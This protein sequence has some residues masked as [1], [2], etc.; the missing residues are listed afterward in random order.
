MQKSGPG[1]E[2]QLGGAFPMHQNVVASIIP[3]E[4]I[5]L[6]YGFDPR[7]GGNQS[8]FLSHIDISLSLPLSLKSINISLVEDLKKK[9]KS[10]PKTYVYLFHPSNSCTPIF[11]NLFFP[12]P[13]SF[14]YLLV[15]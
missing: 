6:G 15:F 3:C 5:H 9:P 10:L 7:S 2:A 4:G 14:I 8:V 12:E 13:T 11:W 1:W